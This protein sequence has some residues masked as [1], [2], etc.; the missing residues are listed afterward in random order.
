MELITF[1][2]LRR[3]RVNTDYCLNEG[4]IIILRSY[5]HVWSGSVDGLLCVCKLFECRIATTDIPTVENLKK[6]A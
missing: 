4:S 2:V 3:V 6:L 5:I 1:V